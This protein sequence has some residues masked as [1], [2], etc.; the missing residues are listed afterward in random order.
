MT[1]ARANNTSDKAKFSEKLLNFFET[2]LRLDQ[3]HVEQVTQFVQPVLRH[4]D[5]VITEVK[6][7]PETDEVGGGWTEM[8]G[9]LAEREAEPLDQIE[10]LVPE[11]DAKAFDHTCS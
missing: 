1:A 7:P 3:P 11:E 4:A 5:R 8:A 9:G 2:G 10:E 6:E